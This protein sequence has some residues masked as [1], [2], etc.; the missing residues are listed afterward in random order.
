MVPHKGC[1]G[2][3]LVVDDDDVLRESLCELLELYGFPT[4]AA[5]DGVEA[6]DRLRGRDRVRFMVLDLLMP[7]MNG[8]QVLSAVANDDELRGLDLCVSTATVERAPA[9]V[10]LLPKPIDLA[11]L[12]AMVEA[13]FAAKA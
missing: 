1:D 10:P 8:L 6:M 9:G 11:R 4:L 3:V 5:R 2:A 13:S 7:R 12:I